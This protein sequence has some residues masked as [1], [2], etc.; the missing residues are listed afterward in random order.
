MGHAAKPIRHNRTLTVDFHDEATY[1]GLL[2]HTKAF[3]EFV[4]AFLLAL[5]FPLLHKASCSEGGCL[6]R[7]S[8]YARVRLG[9]LTI[10]RIQC[11]TCK[12]VFTVLPHLVLRYRTIRPDVARDALWATHGGLSLELCAVICHLS[13]MAVYRLVCSFGH[14]SVVPVLTRCGLPLPRYILADEKHSRC[15]TEKVYLPTIVS[16]RVIWHL[17]YSASKSAAA[18]MESYGDFQRAA[19]QEDPSYQVKGALTDG[20]DSTTSSMRAL[21]PGA[22]LGNCLRHALNKLPD[23]LIGLAAP[24]RQ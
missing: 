4:L 13:P 16:G 6:T 1:F 14:Q 17:G 20:F 5:G 8:H 19:L 3:V 9:G 7:H 2:A 24:V 15:L 22:R 21:F 12:A 23:K 11:T 18:F 10:W